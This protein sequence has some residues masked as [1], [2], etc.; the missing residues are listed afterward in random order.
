MFKKIENNYLKDQI[1]CTAGMDYLF[2]SRLGD[3]FRCIVHCHH[4]DR[5]I[6]NI[7][8]S[9]DLPILKSQV[10]D[11]VICEDNCDKLFAS[12][13]KNNQLINSPKIIF[14][15]QPKNV[16]EVN[17]YNI[18][19]FVELVRGCPNKCF[20]CTVDK[21]KWYKI[22]YIDSSYWIEFLT[23]VA[24]KR[25]GIKYFNISGL[26]ENLLHPQ[27]YD[28]CQTAINLDYMLGL[29][30]SGLHNTHIFK[31]VIKDNYSTLK[32]MFLCLS[33]HPTSYLYDENKIIDL[34]SFLKEFKKVN[35]H[36]TLVGCDEN[37]KHQQSLENIFRRFNF[38]MK[39]LDYNPNH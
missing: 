5:K 26:G 38:E 17:T 11:K 39:V 30:T 25:K 37:I 4:E 6:G 3:I 33:L 31:N 22:E 15:P 18:H 16:D 21:H 1:V 7:K 24:K 8:N 9:N 13:W 19:L 34:L 29:T 27:F 28:I 14:W 36:G 32:K 23:S 2:V 35:V 12:H 10:C 20:Y